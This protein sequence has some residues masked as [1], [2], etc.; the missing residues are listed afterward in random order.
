MNLEY[1]K[2][3]GHTLAKVRE[4]W[5]EPS[6]MAG[7]KKGKLPASLFSFFFRIKNTSYDE[8]GD[9]MSSSIIFYGGSVNG[10]TGK[11]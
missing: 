9:R 3:E 11:K 10:R 5:F 2:P 4:D 7:M 1:G 8:E 6:K